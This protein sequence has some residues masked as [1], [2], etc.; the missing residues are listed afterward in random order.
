MHPKSQCTFSSRNKFHS[1]VRFSHPLIYTIASFSNIVG[2]DQAF[3][4]IIRNHIVLPSQSMVINIQPGS[5]RPIGSCL[6]F[7]WHRT[8]KNVMDSL[9]QHHAISFIIN[10]LL[11]NP[12]WREH[13]VEKTAVDSDISQ[14]LYHVGGAFK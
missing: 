5:A 11:T 4:L 6:K 2:H 12:R 13:V 3:C 7:P 10:F 14:I 8:R 1:Y 9:F